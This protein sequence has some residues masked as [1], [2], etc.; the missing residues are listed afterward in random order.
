MKREE[1]ISRLK[2]KEDSINAMQRI[3][4]KHLVILM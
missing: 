2:L 4:I 3:Y 1:R